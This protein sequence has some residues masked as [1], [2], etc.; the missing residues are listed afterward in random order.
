MIGIGGA[1]LSQA[2]AQ[3]VSQA[4]M[5]RLRAA[6]GDVRTMRLSQGK[7]QLF[8]MAQAATTELRHALSLVALLGVCVRRVVPLAQ[9]AREHCVPAL[10]GPDGRDCED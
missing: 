5:P 3:L 10:Q 4:P 6:V 7:H 9:K 1:P 2:G 8:Q